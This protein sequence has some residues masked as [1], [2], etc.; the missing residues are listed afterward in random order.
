MTNFG[1]MTLKEFASALS[2]NKPT[3]GGGSASAVALSQAGALT[4]MVANLTLGRERYESG[5]EAAEIALQ[6]GT[7]AIEMGHTLA[8]ADASGYDA[9]MA[10]FRMPKETDDERELRKVTIQNASINAS[11]PPMQIAELSLDLMRALPSL[12]SLGNSNA[13]TDVGVAALLS[14][15]AC[16][17]GLFNAEINIVGMDNEIVQDIRSS[18]SSMR[19]ECSRIAR[20]VMHLVHD[21]LSV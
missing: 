5:W 18:I 20:E 12:A 9:V 13:I 10:A 1:D 21:S 2:S 7:K 4:S 15:A 8:D 17:G 6:V 3:P 14:S 19:E 16:K 11:K